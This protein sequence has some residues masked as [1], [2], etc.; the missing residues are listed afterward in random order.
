MFTLVLQVPVIH[1]VTQVK[2]R[3][4]YDAVTTHLVAAED[5]VVSGHV[6]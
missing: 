2:K 4:N 3:K 5:G 6:A 1:E